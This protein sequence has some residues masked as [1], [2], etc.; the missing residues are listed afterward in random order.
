MIGLNG[1]TPEIESHIVT[2]VVDERRDFV[3]PSP[4]YKNTLL[5]IYHS[6]QSLCFSLAKINTLY[7]VIIV[8]TKNWIAMKI[9]R[10]DLLLIFFLIRLKS[11]RNLFDWIRWM[12]KDIFF[13]FDLEQK[14]I[15][16]VIMPFCN[17]LVFVMP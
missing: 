9:L 16:G 17:G 1:I 14:V 4:G 5:L 10:Q 11:R 12:Q 6:F 3:K 2:L 7:F 8:N 15:V 13:T